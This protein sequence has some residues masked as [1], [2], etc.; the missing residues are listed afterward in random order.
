MWL[1]EALPEAWSKAARFFDLADFLT[2]K[3]TGTDTFFLLLILL[4]DHI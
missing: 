3:C 2:Y 1:K 4:G